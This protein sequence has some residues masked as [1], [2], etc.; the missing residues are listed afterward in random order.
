MFQFAV[1]SGAA[2]VSHN[3]CQ[4]SLSRPW[5]Y[6]G[7]PRFFIIKSYKN[8]PLCVKNTQLKLCL[9]LPDI[10]RFTLLFVSFCR[11]CSRVTV[12]PPVAGHRASD[13]ALVYIATTTTE[14][15]LPAQKVDNI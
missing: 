12:S 3:Y 4:V 15:Y 1:G 14:L 6:H 9:L 10:I 5:L 8:K 2:Q 13:A 7:I 11:F